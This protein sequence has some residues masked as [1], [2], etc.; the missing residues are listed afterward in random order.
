MVLRS[1]TVKQIGPTFSFQIVTKNGIKN[2][3]SKL[4]TGVKNR[5]AA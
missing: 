3:L 4:M 2:M 1:A 5:S